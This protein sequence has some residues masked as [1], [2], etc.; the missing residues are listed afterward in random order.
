MSPNLVL[1]QLI[2]HHK[3]TLP[4]NMPISTFEATMVNCQWSMVNIFF[5]HS[6]DLYN[7]YLIPT[8]YIHAAQQVGLNSFPPNSAPSET[9]FHRSN[10]SWGAASVSV[11]SG[12]PL[13]VGML[14]A[15]MAEGLI[16]SRGRVE[17]RKV[18]WA[19]G[20]QVGEKSQCSVNVWG[21]WWRVLWLRHFSSLRIVSPSGFLE[22]KVMSVSARIYQMS[23]LFPQFTAHEMHHGKNWNSCSARS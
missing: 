11:S 15:R 6:M 10:P 3:S 9:A 5:I 16:W 21:W 17:K 13:S 7:Q 23:I 12:F 19:T 4:P 22:Y 14:S 18:G 1:Q 2:S 20:P 8:I